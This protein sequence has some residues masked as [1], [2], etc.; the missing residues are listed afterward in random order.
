MPAI[1]VKDYRN[2]GILLEQFSN[3]VYPNIKKDIE[4]GRTPQELYEALIESY[5]D[6]VFFSL[7]DLKVGAYLG[8]VASARKEQANIGDNLRRIIT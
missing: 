4:H 5:G 2:I 8:I 6:D 1:H 7:R 3:N